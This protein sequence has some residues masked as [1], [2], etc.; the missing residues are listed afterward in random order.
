LQDSSIPTHPCPPTLG[1]AL[2]CQDSVSAKK[3]SPC[4]L[5]AAL[6]CVRTRISTAYCLLEVQPARTGTRTSTAYCLLELQPARTGMRTSPLTSLCFSLYDTRSAS[7]KPS[8][9]ITK[10]MEEVGGRLPRHLR[11][12]LLLHLCDGECRVGV[13]IC[14]SRGVYMCV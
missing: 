1:S 4:T 3:Q 6:S 9:A 7:V 10:L 14:V 8:C 5:H 12:P 13:C 2:L 11:P